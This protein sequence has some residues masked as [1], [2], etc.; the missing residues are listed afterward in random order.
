MKRYLSMIVRAGAVLIAVLL[1]TGVPVWAQ[2]VILGLNYIL[3]VDG[4]AARPS[5]SYIQDPDT[6]SY[7]IGANNRGFSAGGVKRLDYNATRL[8]LSDGYCLQFDGSA[9]LCDGGANTITAAGHLIFTDATYDIG[10]S[11]AT[12]P[13]HGFFSGT[14]TAGGSAEVGNTG[15]IYFA[16]RSR[17]ASESDGTFLF[18]NSGESAAA[19]VFIRHEIEAITTSKTPGLTESNE[20]Y[21]NTGDAD[22]TTF[23]L[24]NDPTAGSTFCF[25]S[26]VAQTMT[27]SPNT[28]E[29]IRDNGSTCSDVRIGAAIGESLT[30]IAATGGSG[31]LW[32][33]L[34]SHGGFT[35][36]P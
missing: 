13:R 2:Q 15:R 34:A 23:T 21:T 35:C 7:R 31:A 20:C 18:I 10:A 22:G 19:A 12:R 17:I 14:L 4:T 1:L 29:S 8:N 25:V 27:I 5:D 24:P 32:I 6:G 30:L 26:T 16:T 36:T 3:H 11:G 33:P 9:T 28:G